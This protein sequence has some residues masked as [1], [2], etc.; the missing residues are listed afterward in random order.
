MKKQLWMMSLLVLGM[1]VTSLP[2]EAKDIKTAKVANRKPAENKS[3]DQ[4]IYEALNVSVCETI[5]G[6]FSPEG[7]QHYLSK[8]VGGL[9]CKVFKEKGP[10]QTDLYE[11]RL[12]QIR[13]NA[14]KIYKALIVP[15]II[16]HKNSDNGY[17]SFGGDSSTK[18]VGDIECIRKASAGSYT[19][20]ILGKPPL[21]HTTCYDCDDSPS[22]E[23]H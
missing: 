15:E 8:S 4:L 20:K 2:A 11:C 23:G 14:Q 12:N 21:P 17:P 18:R 3:P 7:M 13:M 19:C 10:H 6:C 22:Q 16:E 1:A 9:V 5:A